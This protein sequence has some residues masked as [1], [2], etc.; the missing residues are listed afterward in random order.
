ML[1]GVAALAAGIMAPVLGAGSATAAPAAATN[2][3]F[4]AVGSDTIYCE[5]NAAAAAYKTS[6]ATTS[7]NQILN[8]PPVLKFNFGCSTSPGKFVVPLDTV[9]GQIVYKC[10]LQDGTTSAAIGTGGPI[11]SFST[12]ALPQALVAGKNVTVGT[13][14]T[15]DTF[16]TSAA[17][18]IG[19]TTVN[20]VSQTPANAEAAGVGVFAPDCIPG[21]GANPQTSL[22]P[23][24]SSAGISAL[25]ADNGAGNIAYA[26]SSRGRGGSD[27]ANLVFWAFALDAVDWST[28]PGSVAPTNLTTGDLINIFTGVDTNWN[29]ITDIS[30]YTGPNVPIQVW[31]PQAGSGTGKF[32]AQMF[33]GNVYPTPPTVTYGE[34]NNGLS[35]T[36]QGSFNAAE[37]IYPYSVAVHNALPG[38]T[39]G[40]VLG[41]INGVS[42]SKTTITE[43]N[44]SLNVGTG[45]ACTTAGVTGFC[46]SRY[47]Y[48]VTDTLL[49]T[50]H[51]TYAEAVLGLVGIPDGTTVTPTKGFC[52]KQ[53]ATQIKNNG[54]TP[55]ILSATGGAFGSLKSYCR[56][57]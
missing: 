37:A 23:D 24:G 11:T 46:A 22:P 57:S 29:Q 16:V 10:K 18:A 20:V 8:T 43:A 15:A 1:A 35:I 7:K 52:G 38:N 49:T 48:H 6:Q 36:Q 3:R 28:F 14:T 30:G 42:P 5:D 27:S 32:F 13:G 51:K 9:H 53:F 17:A 33:T 40:A 47:V 12:N 56:E 44:A 41:Q 45:D 25:T 39:G 34:E 54:F 31:Y 2:F 21:D 55:L 26:R 19:A 4:N 50:N